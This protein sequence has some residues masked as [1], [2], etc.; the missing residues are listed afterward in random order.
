M[1]VVYQKKADGS[2]KAWVVSI[3]RN[4]KIYTKYFR[5]N[6]Y[7]EAKI[8]HDKLLLSLPPISRSG[9]KK[10]VKG[11]AIKNVAPITLNGCTIIKAREGQ[12]CVNHRICNRYEN[13][14]T[15]VAKRNWPGF[16]TK[17]V[18]NDKAVG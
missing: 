7:E 17:E 13:C 8:Y 16:T 1:S 11:K 12:R 9:P 18:T 5:P 14:L 4:S 6:Q 3:R 2:L 10:G 15:A